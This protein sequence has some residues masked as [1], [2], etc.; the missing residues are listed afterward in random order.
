MIFFFPII[1]IKQSDLA[2]QIISELIAH[3][4][5]HDRDMWNDLWFQKE[6]TFQGEKIYTEVSIHVDT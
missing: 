4:T 5:S 6:Q 1:Y 3:P 2:G